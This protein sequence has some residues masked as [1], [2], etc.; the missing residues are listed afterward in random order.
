ML[1]KLRTIDLPVE[2]GFGLELTQML[3]AIE[4]VQAVGRASSNTSAFPEIK[5]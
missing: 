3:A 4:T 1:P 5:R 2:D